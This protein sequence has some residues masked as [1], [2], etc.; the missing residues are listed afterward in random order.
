MRPCRFAARLA[1]FCVLAFALPV[2]RAAAAEDLA[3]LVADNILIDPA[4]RI[5]ASGHVEVTYRG[6]RLTAARITYTRSS[7]LLRI[8]GPIRVN[9]PNGSVFLASEAELDRSLRNGVLRS[10]RLVL[11]RQLQL[12]ANEI[13]RVGDRYTRLDRVVASSCQVCAANPVPLWEIR[14]DRVIHDQAEQQLYF[15]NAQ[16]RVA[17]VPVFY[18]PRLRLPDPTLK[19]ATGFLI[20]Q[21]TS[22]SKLGFGIKLPYFIALG[23]HADVRLTPYYTASTRTLEFGYRQM[24]PK[25]TLTFDGA[26]SRDDIEGG[27]A[28]LFAYGQYMLPHGFLAEGQL[29]FVSDPGYLYLYN[30]SDKD[31]LANALSLSRVRDRDVFRARI[32]DFRTLRADEIPIQDTLPDTFAEVYYRREA[33][34]LSFGGGRGF[35]SVDFATLNR[36][37][38]VDVDGRD[39]SRIGGSL[40]WRRDGL[41]GPGIVT[42]A[43][44]AVRAD[45]Y[46]IGEDSTYATNLIRVVPRAALELR[47]PWGRT[48]PRGANEVV[49]PVLRFDISRAEG[50]AVPLEDSRVVEFDEGN[51]FAATRYPGVDGVEHGLRA[52]AGASWTHEDPRGWR[53]DLALGRVVR[54]DGSLNYGD[55]SG[56]SG[57]RSQWLVA[58]RLQIDPGLW[59]TSRSLLSNNLAV[60]LSETRLDWQVERFGLASSLLFAQPE[61]SENR[62]DQLSELSLGGHYALNDSWTA[63]ADWRYDFQAGHAARTALGLVYRNECIDV[64]LSLSRRYASST[65][66]NPATEFGFH[67]ALV[68][69]GGNSDSRPDRRTCRG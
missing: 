52:A 29:E 41:I 51:L 67:V 13:A 28:Y 17:G 30:Y 60:T 10:A 35:Y 34:A 43:E 11:D 5:T 64:T 37:S 62:L 22:S 54:L 69:V 65:S 12:A 20:P 42:A 16:L 63:N 31:R 24:L 40:E 57:D 6:T 3:S 15:E 61:P 21:I 56:L 33:V 9:E 8:D 19:R 39:V 7:D 14:A 32:T 68:G 53:L 25:G 2:L 1:L 44:A 45:I 58:G 27:R 55:G 4:G 46:N 50:D 66:V 26:L 59:L 38:T 49:E 36:P 18:L 48:T 47:W 23:D